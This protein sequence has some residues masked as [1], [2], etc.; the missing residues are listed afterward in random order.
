[1]IKITIYLFAMLCYITVT[2]LLKTLKTMIKFVNRTSI[3]AD[4][5]YHD[6]G[7]FW[8]FSG[9]LP[10]R[11]QVY[12]QT[13]ELSRT[14][15]KFNTDRSLRH[16]VLYSYASFIRIFVIPNIL[17]QMFMLILYFS[18]MGQLRKKIALSIN[19][20]RNHIGKTIDDFS[21]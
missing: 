3:L 20:N 17:N 21:K 12:F 6:F 16:L 15:T 1:M 7:N 19:K 13:L 11:T 2:K 18:A 9:S 8:L 14:G 10:A 4:F 5:C